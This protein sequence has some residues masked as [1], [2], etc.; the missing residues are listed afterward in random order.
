MTRRRATRDVLLTAVGWIALLL[1]ILACRPSWSPDGSKLLISYYDPST[2]NAGVSLV[3]L[4]T[5]AAR[6]VF[7]KSEAPSDY[8]ISAQWDQSGEY[9]ILWSD[10]HELLLLPIDSTVPARVLKLPED[11]EWTALPIPEV[12]GSLFFTGDAVAKI[13][14]ATGEVVSR[15]TDLEPGLFV[16]PSGI[17]YVSKTYDEVPRDGRT[18]FVTNGY[19]I[20]RVDERELTLQALFRIEQDYLDQADIEELGYVAVEPSGRRLAF[21]G[22]SDA[23]APIVLCGLEGIERVV[24]PALSADEFALGNI[25]WSSTAGVLYAAALT[26]EE[27][28]DV[29]QFSLA[30]ISLD[31]SSTRLIPLGR[32]QERVVD[33][34]YA[35]QIALSPDGSTI[36]ASAAHFENDALSDAD[37]ALFLVE[38]DDPERP[39]TRI[40][41]MTS[42]K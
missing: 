9:A 28:E 38:L 13:D 17:F 34:F 36:A 31:E 18:H 22:S 16:G 39:I 23:G 35:L 30:E 32:I 3:E 25:E 5:G 10:E 12:D 6:T 26:Y 7:I 29:T 21:S 24:W 4:A 37:R 42:G 8:V 41:L 14:I 33:N 1:Y 2:D 40:P 11:V 19:E 20:G 27:S 15:E